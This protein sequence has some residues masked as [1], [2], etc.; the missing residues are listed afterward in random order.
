MLGL[1]DCP[2]KLHKEYVQKLLIALI[3]EKTFIEFMQIHD[4]FIKHYEIEAKLLIDMD[5]AKILTGQSLYE[6]ALK[7]ASNI[8]NKLVDGIIAAVAEQTK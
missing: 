3:Q 6:G 5:P 4:E 8:S 1:K 7:Q 2:P